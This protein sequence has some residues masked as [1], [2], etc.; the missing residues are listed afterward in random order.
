MSHELITAILL[1]IFFGI[2][3]GYLLRACTEPDLNCK[4]AHTD[5]GPTAA[6]IMQEHIRWSCSGKGTNVLAR[7]HQANPERCKAFGHT[8]HDMGLAFWSTAVAGEAGEMC[9]FIKKRLRGDVI[10]DFHGKVGREIADQI[11]YLDLLCNY[12]HINME[13]YI[14]IKFNEVSAEIGSH[15][16]L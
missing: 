10:E 13:E 7:L 8:V 6:D 5:D 12:L 1:S 16:K 15:I 9:N 14:I 3:C 2:G 11:I 4:R